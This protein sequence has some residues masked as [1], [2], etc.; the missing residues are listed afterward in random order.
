MITTLSQS[1]IVNEIIAKL[2]SEAPE[3]ITDYNIGSILRTII[4]ALAEKLGYDGDTDALYKQLYDTYQNSR[5]D[6]AVGDSLDQLGALVGVTR[7]TG[8]NA[9]GNVTFSITSP[10]TTDLTI[11][12]D[13]Q[14][15]TVPN[16]VNGQKIFTVDAATT[17]AKSVSAE[18][19]TFING[20]YD[21]P[22]A[23]R[24]LDSITGLSGISGGS[25]Y[26]FTENT[27]FTITEDYDDYIVDTSA[28]ITNID[29][30]ES[31][32]GY[33]SN[34]LSLLDACDATTGWSI[35]GSNSIA[36][37]TTAG[38]R[39]EGT[40]CINIVKS[41]TGSN[42][43]NV[44][45]T[46]ASSISLANKE[47][48]VWYYVHDKTKLTSVAVL[49][50]QDNS[51]FYYK[52][53]LAATLIDGWNRLTVNSLDTQFG[54]P[55]TSSVD[56]VGLNI[57]TVANSTTFAGNQQ[58][59]DYWLDDTVMKLNNSDFKQ[60]S[61]SASP[62]K[63]LTSYDYVY[64]DKTI[65]SSS[66]YGKDMH[67][68]MKVKDTTTKNKISKIE[69]Y[70]GN[71]SSNVSFIYTI[72][73]DDIDTVGSWVNY[74]KTA[75]K[76]V[77]SPSSSII[78]F[79]RIKIYTIN[80]SDT[81]AVD[82]IILD[83]WIFGILLP[84]E[85][86]LITF[87]GGTGTTLPDTNTTFKT[88]YVPLSWEVA[89]TADGIGTEYNVSKDKIVYK[90]TYLPEIDSINN[91]EA[92]TGGTD[93][94]TDTALR[95]RIKANSIAGRATVHSIK[96]AI[97]NIEQVRS[98]NVV[99]LPEKTVTSETHVYADGTLSYQLYNK[100]ILDDANWVVSGTT[101]GSG[102]TFVKNTDYTITTED[103]KLNFAT[104]GTGNLPDN[105]TTFYTS[106][107]Y[108]AL[109]YIDV[110]VAGEQI[111][112]DSE[113]SGL[114]SGAIDDYKGGGVILNWYEPTIKYITINAT[115][116]LSSGYAFATVLS[117]VESAIANYISSLGVGDD[118]LASKI[119]AAIMSVTGV[120]NT[121]L[122]DISGGGAVDYTIGV[123][124]VA[125]PSTFTITQ[126]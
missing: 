50:G 41:D 55:T 81:L 23:Q 80:S 86:D 54:S 108:E 123:N 38:E 122:V 21:Y 106:Y 110:Y 75:Y 39:K 70:L 9:G 33:L 66:I 1:D 43:V 84:Y 124:E 32:S 44:Y 79:I 56:F 117:Q 105:N 116:T 94:E 68:K 96:T 12:A 89:C 88:S 10:L 47:V 92:F 42:L 2:I 95:T 121:T 65:T 114:V 34:E 82:D 98:A 7:F 37:N 13:T 67:I 91:Y 120:A 48:S 61:Y 93:E 27:D 40:G 125:K 11:A 103:N 30:F 29:L 31:V 99:E 51:N 15:G 8:G 62:L 20:I 115:I 59:M 118:V 60:G 119:V 4:E 3:N 78:D 22:M 113:T 52:T 77:G 76:T 63:L 71:V 49:A 53:H 100:V 28:S 46:L 6:T 35:S 25:N 107:H 14:I 5:I 104:S 85:G 72:D 109:G 58:R 74:Y 73:K 45:K 18:E 17:F 69:F 57:T 102:M 19:H 26:V 112:M 83:N 126:N 64:Y 36:L 24:F 111:P 87:T 101:S 16:D 90:V 97:E